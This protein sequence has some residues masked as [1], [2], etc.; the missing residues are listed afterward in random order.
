MKKFI[1]D[2]WWLIAIAVFLWWRKKQRKPN[3][4]I[5]PDGKTPYRL[6][7]LKK[8]NRTQLPDGT[9]YMRGYNPGTD[10]NRY[11]TEGIYFPVSITYKNKFCGTNGGGFWMR[12]LEVVMSTGSILKDAAELF[13]MVPCSDYSQSEVR[14]E[15]TAIGVPANS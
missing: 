6:V 2:Y 4:S 5:K 15:L 11:F 3:K 8:E 14:E 13:E 12:V 1:N 10:K 9:P 7:F